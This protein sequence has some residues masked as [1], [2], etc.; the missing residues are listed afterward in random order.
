MT[1]NNAGQTVADY[2]GSQEVS[3]ASGIQWI[4]VP[5][6][7]R[8]VNLRAT[9]NPY[10]GWVD[11]SAE[12]LTHLPKPR[13]ALSLGCGFG[14][15]E[16]IIRQKDICQ[17]I[18]GV[19][20][21]DN[22][23]QTAQQIANESKLSG[24]NYWA[25]DLNTLELPPNTY[26]VVYAHASLHH[27][28]A[29]EHLFDEVKKTLKPGGIFISYEY[30]GPAQMQFPKPHL[31][32]ADRLVKLIPVEYRYQKRFNAVKEEAPRLKLSDMNRVDPSEAIRSQEVLPL[33]A[34]RFAFKHFRYLAGSLLL[35]VF[36][37]IAG[38]FKEGDPVTDP[39]IEFMIYLDNLLVD[40]GILPSYHSYV[41]CSVPDDEM[42][43]QQ[44]DFSFTLSSNPSGLP[45]FS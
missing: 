44:Q 24:L 33:L 28:F 18:D 15:L 38:N 32:I 41:V 22:A 17:F 45:K 39:L 19:D 27:V 30:V 3:K 8:N 31:D 1:D 23:T 37:D 6:I 5:Q 40:S 35:L 36:N 10:L 21:A 9:G 13:K 16:R 11:H 2:W 34:N 14:S 43:A 42:I 20:I 26:D 29:L 25:S 4:E 7:G 12:F